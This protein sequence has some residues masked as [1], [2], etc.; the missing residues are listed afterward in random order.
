MERLPSTICAT[1]FSA[2]RRLQAGILVG[3]A[4]AAV[5]HDGGRQSGRGQFAFR[6]RNAHRVVVG[7]AA[8]AAQHQVRMRIAART[9][10]RRLSLLRDAE[11]MVRDAAPTAGR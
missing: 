5:H 6:H 2:T 10:H 1:Q 3:I 4:V 8:A 9:K 11:K 7:P